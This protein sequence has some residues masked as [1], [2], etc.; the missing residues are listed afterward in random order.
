MSVLQDLRFALRLLVKDRWFSLVAVT[1][2]ALGIGVNATV[3]ALVNA[4]LLRGLP[5]EDSGRLYML[6]VRPPTEAGGG[7][8]ISYQDLAEW[9]ASVPAFEG[10]AA[11]LRSS[12]TVSDG[13]V[14]PEDTPGVWMTANGFDLL[15]QPTLFG[16]GF[17]RGDDAPGAER[18]VILGHALW[19]SRYRGDRSVLGKPIRVNGEPGTII[20]VMQP[21]VK[22]PTNAELWVSAIP[23]PEHLTHRD[24]RPLSVF[25]R[26]RRDASIGQAQSQLDAVVTRLAKDYPG[27]NKELTVGVI[28]TFNERFNAGNVRTVFLAMMGAVGFVLLIACANVANLLLSRSAQRAREVAV[29]YAM[30]ATRWR[31]VRQLLVESLLL[32]FGGGAI[33]LG[34]ALVGVR[35]FD[36]AVTDVGKPYWIQFSVDGVVIGYLIAIC[37]VTSVVFGLAPALQVARTS[38][39]SVLKQGGRGSTGS[40]EMRGFSST[41]VV[42]QL[43]LTLVLL[44]GAGLM[45]RSLVALSAID[46]GIKQE[47]LVAM[48]VSLPRANYP[49][50]EVRAQFFERLVPRIASLPGADGA[51]VST[52]MPPFGLWGREVLI[53]GQADP[54][55]GKRQDAGFV[56]ISPSF[57]DTV[58]APLRRGRAFDARDGGK[59]AEVAIVNERFAARFFAGQ[60]PIGRRIRFP[61]D[62]PADD[63]PWLT[64]VGVSA[65][66]RHGNPREKEI[67]AVAYVPVKQIGPGGATVVVRSR[68]EPSSIVSAVRHEVQSLDP[69]QPV[70]N[71]QTVDQILANTTWPFRVFGTMFG[72]LA[73][74]ALT[75]ASVGLYAVIAYSVSTRTQEIG[76]R[77]ALGAGRGAVGW[78]VLRR[79]LWQL[80]VGL[81]LGLAG[82]WAVG[83]YVLAN[84][85]AQISGTDPG[86]F[87]VVA[88]L[89]VVV[90]IAACI[91]PT[92]RATRL[93]PLAALRVD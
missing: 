82:A 14:A 38:I 61:D 48:R 72:L 76:V 51:A 54:G 73:L 29:R 3:F 31:I 19:Q 8:P 79:G 88:L 63:V 66:I 32:A 53:D 39:G 35:L 81:T 84:V 90:A 42:L 6:G 57:F 93:D 21:G 34:I 64:I 41:L 65:T 49:T 26:L 71:P 27:S 16:R 50:P 62:D 12:M 5:F 36:R 86:L 56:A 80:A 58:G 4:V 92:R 10:L 1:A 37:A 91:I 89:L 23:L 45:V 44:T 47:H 69:D 74:I 30:G 83:K 2:L 67:P 43:A 33:G 60:D 24:Q 40:R 22:F 46:T 7:Q 13:I 75:L 52:S 78:L 77:M 17:R 85:V 28:Q 55:R 25:G 68:L 9:R 59:G 11:F 70:A 18:V 15:R 87:V 20:G